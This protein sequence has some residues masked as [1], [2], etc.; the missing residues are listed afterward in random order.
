M[1][2]CRWTDNYS[3]LVVW[4]WLL[5]LQ[6][7]HEALEL[8]HFASFVFLSFYFVGNMAPGE[9]CQNILVLISHISSKTKIIFPANFHNT[10]LNKIFTSF[11]LLIAI[12]QT[13]LRF[14]SLLPL[15]FSFLNYWIY[16]PSCERNNIIKKE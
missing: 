6:L 13:Y 8:L 7:F 11:D 4:I 2:C 3:R 15:R 14:L 5:Q 12:S 1:E 10:T 16:L 9:L